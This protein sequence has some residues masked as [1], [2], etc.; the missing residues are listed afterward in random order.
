VLDTKTQINPTEKL[1]ISNQIK[2]I[3]ADNSQEEKNCATIVRVGEQF[4]QVGNDFDSL[5]RQKT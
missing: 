4:P 2:S 5:L 3:A 1:A